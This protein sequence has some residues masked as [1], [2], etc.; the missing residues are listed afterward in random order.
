[1]SSPG[2]SSL[3]L[4]VPLT[5]LKWI[6]HRHTLMLAITTS[7]EDGVKSLNLKKQ[8]SCTQMNLIQPLPTF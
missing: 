8:E 3:H 6:K 4:D 5:E 2:S 7:P 1:M